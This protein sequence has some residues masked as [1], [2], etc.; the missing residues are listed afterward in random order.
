MYWGPNYQVIQVIIKKDQHS[1]NWK[2][3]ASKAAAAHTNGSFVTHAHEERTWRV[4]SARVMF[5]EYAKKCVKILRQKSPRVK[6]AVKGKWPRLND[7]IRFEGPARMREWVCALPEGAQLL[8]E[9]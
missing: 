5:D 3:L 6:L 9:G 1:G 2:F 4:P 7:C 8:Y